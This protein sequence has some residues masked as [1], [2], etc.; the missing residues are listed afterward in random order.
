[1]TWRYIVRPIGVIDSRQLG[2]QIAEGMTTKVRVSRHG[3]DQRPD[4]SDPEF[5]RVKLLRHPR[6]HENHS[7]R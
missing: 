4:L 6:G 7:Q 5:V 1:M 2:W 3:T